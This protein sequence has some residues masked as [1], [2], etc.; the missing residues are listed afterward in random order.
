[1]EAVI[2]RPITS[3]LPR[4]ASAKADSTEFSFAGSMAFTM[5][6][7]FWNTVLTSTVTLRDRS[8][9]PGF[10]GTGLAPVGGTMKSTYLAPNAVLDLISAST[11]LGR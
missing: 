8:T 7:R 3:P 5:L 6:C 4:T 10:S 11:L 1:M 9:A 2:A